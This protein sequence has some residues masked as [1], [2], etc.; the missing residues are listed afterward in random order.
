MSNDYVEYDASIIQESAKRL[1]S[2]AASIILS[3]TVFGLLVGAFAGALGAVLLERRSAITMVL[4]ICGLIGG[5]LGY[6]RGR[7]RAFELK[8]QAQVALCQVQIEKNTVAR[9]A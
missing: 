5:L 6:Q 8:L 7:E 9:D 1:Y 3:S 4:A 2:R